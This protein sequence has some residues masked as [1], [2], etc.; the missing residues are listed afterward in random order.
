[1]NHFSH[2]GG[3]EPFLASL[4]STTVLALPNYGDKVF[5]CLACYEALACHSIEL[6]WG[7]PPLR[8]YWPSLTS[9]GPSGSGVTPG[10]PV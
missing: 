9:S 6:T 4:L 8:C 7:W 2:R 3:E 1:M 10:H 5:S